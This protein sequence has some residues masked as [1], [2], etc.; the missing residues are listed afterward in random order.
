MQLNF[1][2]RVLMES[3]FIELEERT[4]S[5]HYKTAKERYN[6][7]LSRYS[8]LFHRV[9]LSHIAS[10]LGITNETLSRIRS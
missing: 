8:D 4:I 3:Y 7:F 2:G 6:Y 1:I 5:L 10:F 9:K